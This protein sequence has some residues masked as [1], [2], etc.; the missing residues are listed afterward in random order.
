MGKLL[1]LKV[2]STA[3]DSCVVSNKKETHGNKNRLLTLVDS[4][5]TRKSKQPQ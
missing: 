5:K 2:V 1:N 4:T 3:I